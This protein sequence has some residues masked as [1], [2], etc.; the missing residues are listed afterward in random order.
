MDG[1]L[2]GDFADAN[3]IVRQFIKHESKGVGVGKSAE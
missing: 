2:F 1:L 3:D